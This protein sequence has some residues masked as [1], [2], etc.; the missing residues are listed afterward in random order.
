MLIIRLFYIVKLI[1]TRVIDM[2]GRLKLNTQLYISFGSILALLA[3]IASTSWFG[4]TRINDGFVEYRGLAKDTNLAGRVQ[5]NMLMMR[6]AVLSY[7]N[8]QSQTSIKQYQ[9]RKTKMLEF[10]QDAEKEIQQPERAAL[11]AK[12]IAEIHDYEHG[13]EQVI[14]LFEQ[15]DKIIKKSLD[16]NGLTMRQ[17]VSEIIVSAYTDSDEQISFI[18]AQL[19]ERLLLGRLYVNKYLVTNEKEEIQRAKKELA[20]RMPFLIEDLQA[21]TDDSVKLELLNQVKTAHANYVE[22]INAIEKIIT[23]RNDLIDNTLNKI[24]PAVAMDI[25]QVKLSVKSEQDKLG[26]EVQHDTENGLFVIVSTSI[27]A[28]LLGAGITIVMPNVIK[29]PIGGEPKEIAKITRNVADG[30]L[31]QTLELTESD[32]GIYKAIGE[33]N[34]QLRAVIT[35]L[36]KN[37]AS[38]TN[39]AQKSADIASQNVN[40]VSHQKQTT[41]QIIVAVE[42]MSHSINEVSDLAKRSEDKSRDGMNRATDGREV[43]TLALNSIQSLSTSLQ[44]SMDAIKNLEQKNT[45]IVSALSVISSISEQTNLLALN[46]AIEAARAGEAGRGFAV[47]A[48]EVRTLA[49]R[50]Q[51]STDEIQS[52]I[53]SLQEGTQKV[54]SVMQSSTQM[55]KETVEQS[56]QTDRA[57][58]MIYETINEISEM[59]TLVATAVSQQSIAANEVTQNMTE[60]RNTIDT[61]LDSANQAHDASE[62]VILVAEQIGDLTGRFKV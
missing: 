38:L 21:S 42:Q 37:N 48:D 8:T 14:S 20:E 61:T 57:L 28:F 43:L 54:V 35:T 23:T 11:I 45:D 32:S 39:S 51:E 34:V 55:A 36:V 47:V 1:I 25:E 53:S 13:F 56:N 40:T 52:I 7:V 31:N 50:T 62:E 12:I 29:R 17:A 59:N 6:L 33:M 58:E 10:L 49:S 3:I 16:P 5:A 15:R 4:F 41:D 46:A 27:I 2:L 18:A 60:I 30:N 26:P 22:A 44:D 19:Q 9:Q 24:G